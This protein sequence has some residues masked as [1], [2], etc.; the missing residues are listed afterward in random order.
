MEPNKYK[1][2]KKIFEFEG[3]GTP[4]DMLNCMQAFEDLLDTGFIEQF[5]NEKN[6]TDYR[7]TGRSGTLEILQD[8]QVRL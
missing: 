1:L 3:D 6:E 8:L 4:N 5:V 7:I 2:I